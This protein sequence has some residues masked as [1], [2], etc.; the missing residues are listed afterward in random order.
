MQIRQEFREMYQEKPKGILFLAIV[1]NFGNVLIQRNLTVA[2]LVD[3]VA[4]GYN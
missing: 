3:Q 2:F 4:Q 1:K